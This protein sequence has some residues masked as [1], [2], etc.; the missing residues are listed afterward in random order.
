MLIA[1]V[2][3][4]EDWIWVTVDLEDVAGQT[5]RLRFDVEGAIAPSRDAWRIGGLRIGSP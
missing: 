5:I 1:T 4:S 3:A 2:P